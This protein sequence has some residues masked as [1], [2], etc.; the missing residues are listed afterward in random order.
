MGDLDDVYKLKED[1]GMEQKPNEICYDGC[2]YTRANASHSG[3]E[4]CFKLGNIG[5]SL[6]CYEETT[7]PLHLFPG[8]TPAEEVPS[9]TTENENEE[10]VSKVSEEKK[11]TIIVR[12][13]IT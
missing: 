12:P 10:P 4:Y 1:L 6:Q 3:E 11:D 9:S 5:G 13:N 7:T 2:I 8:E